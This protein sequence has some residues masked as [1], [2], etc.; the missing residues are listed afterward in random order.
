MRKHS[1]IKVIFLLS[2]LVS[3]ILTWSI[4]APGPVNPPSAAAQSGGS[5]ILAN[6]SVIS[7]F[8]QIPQSYAQSAAAIIIL[9]M[10][11]ST[12][13]YIAAEG[14]DCLAGLH[15]DIASYPQECVTYANNRSA[16]VW[17]YYDDSN[18]N[19]EL[20]PSPEAD[21]LAKTDQFVSIVNSSASGYT[22]IG[23]K[24][25]YTDGWN[26][27]DNVDYNNG[28]GYYITKMEQL[29]QQY[30]GVKFIYAT[31]ALWSDPGTACNSIF[32]SCAE[33]SRFN[34]QVRAYTQA[35]NKPLFDIA[36]IESHD[37]SGNLCT[38]QGYEGMCPDWYS[39]GGGHPNIVG[40]IRLA[41]G[42]WWLMARMAGWNAGTS[43]T[44]TAT[45]TA[46]NTGLPPTNTRTPTNTPAVSQTPTRTPTK[47]N[48]PAASQ[49]PTR[50][51]TSTQS[52]GEVVDPTNIGSLAAGTKVLI[53]FN[54]FSNPVDGQPI[55]SSY[56]GI[57]WNSLVKGSPWAG[58]STW[59]FYIDGGGAQG[60]IVFP[61]PVIVNSLRASSGTN[62]SL[63]LSSTGNPDVR[64]ITSG[65]SPLTLTTGWTNPVTSLVVTSSTQDQAFD[66]LRF[67]ISGP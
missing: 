27:D 16:R 59:N 51:P 49:T 1:N 44:P 31:S 4:F 36:D 26:Q 3:L 35:N 14:L 39:D 5:A 21:A 46:T 20:W 24:F 34:A 41:K 32:N 63:T 60:T 9:F 12:G 62:N 57:T 25:C 37:S 47:T 50:T 19:W 55:P 30:P 33:I 65:N 10:H 54:N 7:Q 8:S 22:I 64:I 58:I 17:P 18:W 42:F 45:R 56:A 28:H 23:M 67:T 61:R 40:S 48:T 15:G 13:G 66:D 52:S 2:F 6:H 11:Q 29:E 38:V 53:D 43:N